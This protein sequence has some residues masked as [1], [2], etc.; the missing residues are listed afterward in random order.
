MQPKVIKTLLQ[1]LKGAG[2][3]PRPIPDIFYI[4]GG[5]RA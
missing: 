5:E 3:S 4:E 1:G 2:K